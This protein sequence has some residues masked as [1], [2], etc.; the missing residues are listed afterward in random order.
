MSTIYATIVEVVTQLPFNIWF[1]LVWL[2]A[3]TA[4]FSAKP[5]QSGRR[6]IMG[7]AVAIVCTYA[8]ATLAIVVDRV[9]DYQA[10]QE[11]QDQL[12][13]SLHP[14]GKAPRFDDCAQPKRKGSVW[15]ASHIL[16]TGFLTLVYVGFWES[17]WRIIYRQTKITKGASSRWAGNV[18]IISF[19]GCAGFVAVAT[20]LALILY[21][22]PV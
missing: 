10:F 19:W 20:V 4:A 15:S 2:V 21:R 3:P 12:A 17:L 22:W 8:L 9:S 7:L 1:W 18:T 14:K 11:C 16:P 5:T 6:Y 13:P